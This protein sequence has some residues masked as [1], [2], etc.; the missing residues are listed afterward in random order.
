M[1]LRNSERPAQDRALRARICM[2]QLANRV[3]RNAGYGFGIFRRVVL[4]ARDVFIKAGCG[5][6]DEGAIYQAGS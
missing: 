6:L 3:G 1:V 5:A 4:Y 2:R